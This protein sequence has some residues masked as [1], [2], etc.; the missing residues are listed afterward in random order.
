[1][2]YKALLTCLFLSGTWA[3]S[4]ERK[5][6]AGIWKLTLDTSSSTTQN[7]I[8]IK[9]QDDG[10][11]LQFDENDDA[12]LQGCWDFEDSQLQLAIGRASSFCS[13]DTLLAGKISSPTGVVVAKGVV[14]AGKFMYPQSHMAFFDQ[15]LAASEKIGKFSLKQVMAFNSIITPSRIEEEQK[16][17][18]KF[19]KEDF[20]N[21]Q[22]VMT[23][24]PIECKIKPQEVWDKDT[25][26]WRSPL[27]DQAADIRTLPIQFFANSTFEAIGV[28]KVLRGRFEVTKK[29]KLWFAVSRFGMGRSTSGSV[30]SEGIGLSHEDERTYLGGIEVQDDT[31][32]VSGKVTFG[33][34]LGSDARPEPVGTF[35]LHEVGDVSL[36]MKQEDEVLDD[37]VFNS[38]FE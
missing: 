12:C 15:V 22:F 17:E 31:F 5:N 33:A 16:V 1:M 27:D 11:F 19:K 18:P 3:F 23:V 24:V 14:S 10:S 20:F 30:Y 36:E 28:N 32:R 13:A 26:Q 4:V 29:D 9:L 7:T 25:R 35:L 34:D 2:L 37:D 21:R 8:T 38:V 6:L